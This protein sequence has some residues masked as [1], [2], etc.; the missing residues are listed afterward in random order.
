MI[1]KCVSVKDVL[2]VNAYFYISEK[3]NHGFL[4]DPGAEASTLIKEIQNNNWVIEKILLTHGHFDH[5]GAV[6]Q[7]FNVLNIP[8]F[9]HVNGAEYLLN[10][11]YNLSMYFGRDI[12]LK[13]ADYFNDGDILS[14]DD[15]H[16]QVISTPGHTTDSVVFYDADSKIAFVGDTI[17]R[18][19]IGA[20]HFPGGDEKKLAKSIRE[21]IFTLPEETVLYSGHSEKTDVRTEKRRY[22]ITY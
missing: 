11:G 7:L 15:I 16:L 22:Y 3:T 9:I 4:I 21:K 2:D 17:F 5:I 18:G 13:N 12:I 14:I 1:L 6:D 8:Y 10:A 19:S 20:T